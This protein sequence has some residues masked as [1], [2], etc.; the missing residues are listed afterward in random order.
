M[1]MIFLS[2]AGEDTPAAKELAGA[3]RQ[4]GL[5]VWLDVERLR[6]G[7]RWMEGIEQ[8]LQEASALVV[9][10]GCSGVQSW[11]DREVRVALDR[12]TKDPEFRLIPVLGSGS[13]PENLPTFLKQYQWID[14]R[15][16]L[17]TVDQLKELIEGITRQ[18]AAGPVSLLPPDKAP[19]R[20]LLRFGAE[21]ALL[22]YGRDGEIHELL[23]RMKADNFLAV[24]GD[25][26]SGKSSLVRAGLIPALH[27][28][29]FHGGGSWVESWRIAVCR[30]GDDPFRELA[31]TL[32]DLNPGMSEASR[33]EFIQGTKTEFAQG[34]EGLRNRIVALVPGGG[35]T[36]LVVD[37]FE[38]LFT[39][40]G[41]VDERRRFIDSL[42]CAAR[43]ET[44]RPV[45]IVI[46]LRADFYSHCW[47]HPDLPKRIAGNQYAVRRVGIEQL[48][49]VIE[50]PLALVGG[51]AEPGLIDDILN[52]VGDE[53]G[54]LPLLE[55]ALL[56]LWGRREAQTLTH[57]AYKEIG[58]LSGALKNHANQVYEDLRD[59]Q[60]QEL[61]RKIFLRLTQLGE[62]SEDTRRRAGKTE[63]LKIGADD[64]TAKVLKALTD[65]RLITT[66]GKVSALQDDKREDLVEVA[67]E[68]L[69]REW[70]RMRNWVNEDRDALRIERRILQ[71]AKDWDE[72]KV[73]RDPGLLLTGTR[74][75]EAKEWATKHERELPPT[76][77]E[78][79]EASDRRAEDEAWKAKRLRLLAGALAVMVLC[80]S[81]W[82]SYEERQRAQ[83]LLRET[84]VTD[85]ETGWMWTRTDNIQDITW[86][87]AEEYCENLTLA[88]Y[89]NWRLPTMEELVVLHDSTGGNPYDIR[90]PFR[91]SSWWVWSAEKSGSDSA[92][93]FDFFSGRRK[94]GR[95]DGSGDHRALCVRPS[96]E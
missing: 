51:G 46:T 2:H 5:E 53:P 72:A 28:G 59:P 81:V 55:H 80:F 45:H 38:E 44:E 32:P 20:G 61:A 8:G 65:S 63:L 87:A 24:V 50:K 77:K 56:Q 4:A 21:D 18:P 83:T 31:E 88:D 37:Q 41:N 67:H 17:G 7:D 48:R 40:T 71:S 39:L 1:P 60:R 91:L 93:F 75:A 69:I 6:P 54:H 9:Y 73:K 29:R 52:D 26:G 12:S 86:Y 42:F 85:P 79:L 94:G 19:F 47:Q 35:H 14:W 22:F 36:L 34:A 30:P 16:G 57:G 27:R 76:A 68:A 89:S 82:S 3:L 96:G 58:R 43:S 10:V 70:P 25:S 23:D 11:V 62:G 15:D 66:S 92:W 74:L 90:N 78:F 64:E 13:D 49:E 33:A 84:T 95:L